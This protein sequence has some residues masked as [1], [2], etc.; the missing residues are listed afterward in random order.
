MFLNSTQLRV[1]VVKVKLMFVCECASTFYG[2]LQRILG[3]CGIFAKNYQVYFLVLQW[4][5][6]K[7]YSIYILEVRDVFKTSGFQVVA[8]RI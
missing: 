5:Q 2:K 8:K 3:I 6:R 1:K 4:L 7:L